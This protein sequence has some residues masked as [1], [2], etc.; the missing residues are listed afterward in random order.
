MV[1]KIDCDDAILKAL[2]AYESLTNRKLFAETRK[3]YKY[4]ETTFNK[5]LKIL[6][7]DGDVIKKQTGKQ[8]VEYSVNQ[9]SLVT[10]NLKL[11]G[12]SI[13][14]I[15]HAQQKFEKILKKES[16]KGVNFESLLRKKHHIFEKSTKIIVSSMKI[17]GLCDLLLSTPLSSKIQQKEIT[18]VRSENENNIKTLYQVFQKIDPKASRYLFSLVKRDVYSNLSLND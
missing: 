15:K 9:E 11:L 12:K 14:L 13:K 5:Y 17:S 16:K 4:S 2:C 18:K 6:V 3:N 10:H 1:H 8:N 7:K